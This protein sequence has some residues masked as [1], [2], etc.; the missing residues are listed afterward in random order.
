MILFAINS[1]ASWLE[2]KGLHGKIIE[3]KEKQS[4]PIIIVGNKRVRIAS[5]KNDPFLLMNLTLLLYLGLGER[6]GS[7]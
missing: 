7:G 2:M 1:R 5:A 6:A 3:D 4:I